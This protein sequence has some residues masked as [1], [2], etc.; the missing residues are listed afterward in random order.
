MLCMSILQLS[1]GI[2]SE[3]KHC[4]SLL[5]IEKN[6]EH[7]SVNSTL[8]LV[9]P[10]LFLRH[11]LLKSKILP[12]KFHLSEFIRIHTKFQYHTYNNFFKMAILIFSGDKTPSPPTG[13]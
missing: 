13:L 5:S 2:E 4:S 9:L 12:K 11:S 6:T 7:L 1:G 10:S 8:A 3:W